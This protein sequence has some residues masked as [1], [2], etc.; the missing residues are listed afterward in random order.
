MTDEAL[1][2]VGGRGLGADV[3]GVG[4]IRLDV[5]W[6]QW[7]GGQWGGDLERGFPPSPCHA[8][9]DGVPGVAPLPPAKKEISSSGGGKGG[10]Q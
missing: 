6:E 5:G 10:K 9:G 1:A 3:G 8:A 2:P 7:L 4:P